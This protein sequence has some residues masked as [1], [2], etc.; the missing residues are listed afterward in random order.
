MPTTC[1]WNK[2]HQ[3]RWKLKVTHIENN[4][5]NTHIYQ[6]RNDQTGMGQSP[7][8]DLKKM[9]VLLIVYDIVIFLG[10]WSLLTSYEQTHSFY[11]L[12]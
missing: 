2:L 6:S 8:H 10:N 5:D 12:L 11:V 3:V 9:I 1:F 4:I 7:L